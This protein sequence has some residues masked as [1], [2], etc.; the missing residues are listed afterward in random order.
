MGLVARCSLAPYSHLLDAS[1]GAPTYHTQLAV[2][3]T[4]AGLTQF[5]RNLASLGAP[6]PRAALPLSVP[7]SCSA[8][9]PLFLPL[10]PRSRGPVMF[11]DTDS[12]RHSVHHTPFSTAVPAPRGAITALPVVQPRAGALNWHVHVDVDW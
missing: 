6:A 8:W 10:S 11:P 4:P 7:S 3:A 5:A 12:Q 1:L 2:A 9:P